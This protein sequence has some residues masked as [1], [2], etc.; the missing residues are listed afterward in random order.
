MNNT[1]S[2]RVKSIE[3]V[4]RLNALM[5]DSTLQR[6]PYFFFFNVSTVTRERYLPLIPLSVRCTGGLKGVRNRFRA[7]SGA[8]GRLEAQTMDRFVQPSVVPERHPLPVQY[9]V[10]VKVSVRAFFQRRFSS[11]DLAK[12]RTFRS[13]LSIDTAQTNFCEVVN[14]RATSL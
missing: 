7:A 13:G 4:V 2:L 3:P 12:N 9:S 8:D 14:S 10:T 6:V 1:R 5:N 11:N